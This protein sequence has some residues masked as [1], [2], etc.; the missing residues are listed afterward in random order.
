MLAT[1]E[2]S[3]FAFIPILQQWL[4]TGAQYVA[5]TQ[6][7]LDMHSRGP[8]G[9]G[10]VVMQ[11]EHRECSMLF[12]VKISHC[13]FEAPRIQGSQRVIFFGTRSSNELS[14]ASLSV[15]APSL[16]G[17]WKVGCKVVLSGRRTLYWL[18]C[19]THFETH[20]T[21]HGRVCRRACTVPSQFLAISS[22]EAFFDRRLRVMSP[23]RDF[24]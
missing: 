24:V 7:V 22:Q 6:N 9:K 16:D 2:L 12:Q 11:Q 1:L 5:L 17:H 10:L 18:H 15:S 23:F 20:L 13:S 8:E 21:D 3:L 19:G 14:S 4:E